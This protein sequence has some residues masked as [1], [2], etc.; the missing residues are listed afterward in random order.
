[1][2]L[3]RKPFLGIFSVLKISLLD[4]VLFFTKLMIGYRLVQLN[5]LPVF[6]TIAKFLGSMY[7]VPSETELFEELPER[8]KEF[9]FCLYHSDDCGLS[10]D[11]LKLTDVLACHCTHRSTLQQLSTTRDRIHFLCEV[12]Q[13]YAR[14]D[15]SSG[16]KPK[17]SERCVDLRKL[18]LYPFAQAVKTKRYTC[19]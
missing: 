15:S 16:L 9:Y 10:L 1:M 3:C 4:V 17:T 2:S 19:Q 13:Q 7:S 8:L 5:L 12:Q 11:G 18:Y 14:Q 6:N